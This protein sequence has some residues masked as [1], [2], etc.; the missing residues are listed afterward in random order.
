MLRADFHVHTTF[1][2]DC[3]TSLEKLIARCL[4]TKI[5]CIAVS[6][7]GTIEGALKMQSLA[8]FKVIVAEEILT[9]NGE[10]IG[11][12]L[13]E[14]IPSH[15]P[16]EEAIARIKDQDGLICLPHPFDPLR[17]LKLNGNRIEKLAEQVDIIE[18]FN[19][20][21]PFFRPA[22]KARELALKHNLPET[23]ASDAHSTK[24]IGRTYVEMPE[25]NDK[26]EFLQ[27]L[28]EGKMFKH[29]SSFL[30]HFKTTWIKL[31]RLL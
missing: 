7:H 1:S 17:G 6:D 20:R 21:S 26:D 30:V 16:L 5:N 13:K 24:E 14:G 31:K 2:K 15:I 9:D 23:V 28:R 8:P 25:F 12:F 3:E 18:V 4:E 19:A 27:A 10:I 11:M 22:R 29:R